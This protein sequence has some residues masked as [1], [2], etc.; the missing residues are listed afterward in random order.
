MSTDH[1]LT[2]AHSVDPELLARSSLSWG[3]YS[4][5]VNNS[6]YTYIN[7]VSVSLLQKTSPYNKQVAQTFV[8]LAKEIYQ[9]SDIKQRL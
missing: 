7:K 8:R 3:R 2:C 1:K 6:I 5:K 9:S 4:S